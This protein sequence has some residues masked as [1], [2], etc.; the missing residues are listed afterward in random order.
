MTEWKDIPGYEGIYRISDDRRVLSLERIVKRWGKE[1]IQRE[2]IM[3]PFYKGV[4]KSAYVQLN[5]NGK[6]RQM[7]IE[8]MCQKLFEGKTFE[9]TSKHKGVYLKGNRWQVSARN[10]GKMVWIGSFETEDEAHEARKEFLLKES[11]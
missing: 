5:K 3:K 9:K 8:R 10:Y 2:K 4:S 1:T 6:Q 7:C 11:K